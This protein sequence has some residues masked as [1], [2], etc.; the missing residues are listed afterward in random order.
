MNGVRRKFRKLALISILTSV[1][2]FLPLLATTNFDP[3]VVTAPR[4]GGG[5]IICTGQACA[6]IL[7]AMSEQI[8]YENLVQGLPIQDEPPLSKVQFCAYLKADRPSG[9]SGSSPPPSPGISV[10]GKPAWQANGCGTGGVGT[11]FQDA[12]L[13]VFASQSYSGDINSPFPGVSF[14]A[15]CDIHDECWASGVNR[16][17]C[18]MSFQAS[19]NTACDQLADPGEWGTCRGFSSNY[20]GAVSTTNG[21]NSA[22]ASS[23][24]MRE[25]ALWAHNMRGNSCAF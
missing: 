1:A 8:N 19:M 12:V 9:C 17:V 24:S 21:S 7:G 15:S 14:R 11:W 10:P 22:Y 6:S 25:C 4:I 2:W 5:N 3:I 23:V 13:E 16:T 18:D 20:H